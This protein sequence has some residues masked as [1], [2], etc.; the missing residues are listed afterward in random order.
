ML[1]FM[2]AMAALAM[3][4]AWSSPM[5]MMTLG[6]SCG[7]S[8]LVSTTAPATTSS[9]CGGWMSLAIAIRSFLT[10]LPVLRSSAGR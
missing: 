6:C 8:G 7:L 2:C 3:Y 9:V 5:R 1:F 10:T 4:G